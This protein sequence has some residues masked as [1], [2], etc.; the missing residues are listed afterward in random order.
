MTDLKNWTA[1]P[2]PERKALEGTYVRLEPL[3]ATRHGDGLF[4]ASSVPDADQRFTWLGNLYPPKSRSEYQRWLEEAAASQDPF[5]FTLIDRAG[6]AVGGYQALMRPDPANGVIEIGYIYWGPLIA[7]TRLATEAFYLFA[8]YIFDELGYRRYEWKC[9]NE[10][11]PSKRAAQRF[12]F[13]F[14][15]IFRQHMVA[16]GKNRD[17]AWFSILDTEW[18]ALRRAYEAW[19]APDNFDADGKQKKRL[20]ELR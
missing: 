20:E 7:R 15:G 17:T 12:G 3:D 4:A 1:R 13:Q 5:F 9:H 8:R 16:K 14:E 6:G 18:P 11:E 19:L 2:L 10:N